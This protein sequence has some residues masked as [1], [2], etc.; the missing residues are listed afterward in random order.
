MDLGRISAK[1]Q[2]LIR[3]PVADVYDAFANPATMRRFWFGCRD[4]RLQE[5][6]TVTWTLGEAPDAPGFEVRVIRLVPPRM[7]IV[8]W[9]DGERRTTVTWRFE[10][11]DARTTVLRVEETGFE[12]DPEEIV[13]SAL[14]STGGFNQVIVAAKAL[15]EH[16]VA[17]N[18]V[19]DRA[20]P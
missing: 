19:A 16:G 1:A 12:G 5:G 4:G 8:E 11:R 7:M 3:R 9:G 18:V 10:R 17:I 20:A 15:L 6:E 2:I 13:S 14:D